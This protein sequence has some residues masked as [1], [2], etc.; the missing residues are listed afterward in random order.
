MTKVDYVIKLGGSAITKKHQPFTPNLDVIENISSE[1]SM[2]RPRPSLI[3]VYGGGSFGH[4]VARKYVQNGIITDIMG[5]AEIHSAM[6][7]LTK[8]LTDHLLQRGIPA[9]TINS[10]ATFVLNGQDIQEAFLAPLEISLERGL[11][12]LIGGDVAFNL[13]SG[14]RILS[15]DRIATYLAKYFNARVLAFGTDVDGV[16]LEGRAVRRINVQDIRKIL[17]KIRN[18][19][20]DV[21]GGMVGKLMEISHYM[22]EGGKSAI[23]FNITRPGQLTRLLLGEEVLGTNF[24]S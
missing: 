24:E 4:P 22:S 3:L 15:G 18:T 5:V 7:S 9:I 20:E 17:D 8:I 23:I 19:H 16:I 21:T 6:L 2:I 10:S 11:I 1:I 12:P 14:F 13:P